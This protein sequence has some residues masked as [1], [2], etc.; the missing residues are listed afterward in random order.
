MHCYLNVWFQKI[1]IPPPWKGFAVWPPLPSGFSKISPQ[2][3]PPPLRNFHNFCTPLEILL[4]LIEVNKE[5]VLFTRMPNFVS[6]MYFLLNCITDKRIPYANS[7]CAQVTDKFCA[8]HVISIE[9]CKWNARSRRKHNCTFL[10]LRQEESNT[11]RSIIKEIRTPS[12]NKT[13]WLS[14]FILP[15]LHIWVCGK[16][17][18]RLFHW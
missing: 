4:S 10:A 8:F 9:F 1:S 5:V 15:N 7:L 6:F 2:I 3:Y 13:V 14:N 12:H 18:R 11:W 17:A 16:I